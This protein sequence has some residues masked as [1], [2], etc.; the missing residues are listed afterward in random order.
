MVNTNVVKYMHAG[1]HDGC[2]ARLEGDL[3]SCLISQ[4]M[5]VEGDIDK[6]ELLRHQ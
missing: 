4:H 1:R 3:V 2:V 6:A 5:S